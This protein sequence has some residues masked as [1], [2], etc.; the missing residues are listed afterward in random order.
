MNI[1]Q[2]YETY[3]ADR[4]SEE[5]LQLATL[6]LRRNAPLPTVDESEEWTEQDLRDATRHSR[7]HIAALLDAEE[8]TSPA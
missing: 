8:E 4:T 1:F 5:Q 7:T 2:I 6:I 3:V